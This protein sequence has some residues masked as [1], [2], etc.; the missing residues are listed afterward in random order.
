MVLQPSGEHGG[1]PRADWFLEMMDDEVAQIYHQLV[2]AKP[3][4]VYT[5]HIR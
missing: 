1:R 5:A 2:P 3:P 4:F